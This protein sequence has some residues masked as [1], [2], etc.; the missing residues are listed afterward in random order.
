MA[1]GITDFSQAVAAAKAG[2]AFKKRIEE[3]KFANMI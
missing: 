1:W 3:S 2:N